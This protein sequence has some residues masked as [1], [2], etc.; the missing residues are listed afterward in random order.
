LSSNSENKWGQ[1]HGEGPPVWKCF[2][3]LLTAIGWSSR[4]I[5]NG[6]Q[7]TNGLIMI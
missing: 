2:G 5:V 1:S 6:S 3:V 4:R 7:P